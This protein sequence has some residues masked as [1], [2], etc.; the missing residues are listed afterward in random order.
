[1]T[2]HHQRRILLNAHRLAQ[3]A[4]KSL[5]DAYEEVI[6]QGPMEPDQLA[7]IRRLESEATRA[8]NARVEAFEDLI[9]IARQKYQDNPD[10]ADLWLKA[11]LVDRRRGRSR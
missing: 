5:D 9:G 1:M 6:L 11:I 7:N 4:R 10:E 8:F 2:R 3:H